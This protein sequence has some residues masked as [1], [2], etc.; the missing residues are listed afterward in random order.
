MFKL[1]KS[2]SLIISLITCL[3]SSA[4][5]QQSI[6]PDISYLFLEKL[7]ATA[8]QNYPRVKQLNINKGI[9]ELNVKHQ[10]LSWLDPLSASYFSTSNNQVLN[11]TDT[12]F[13][14]NGY[15]I[16]AS[17]NVGSFLQKPINI[18]KSKSEL[19]F[20][21]EIANEYAL[22]LESEVKRRYFTY[23]EAFNNVKLFT[24]TLQ[25]AEGMKNDMRIRYERGEIT[26]DIYSQSLITF[27]TIS[28]S[29]ISSEAAMLIAK[30]SLEELTIN[31]IEDIQ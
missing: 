29:K 26:F 9:A 2:A 12:R 4:G 1:I 10:K 5:A 21:N 18:K 25:D 14:I 13:L 22:Q 7:I 19:L 28:Q 27:S 24:K 23:I 30:A 11:F 17:V 3:S 8:K 6:I 31:R 20:A 16:G 15:Q